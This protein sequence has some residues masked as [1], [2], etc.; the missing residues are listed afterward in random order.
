MTYHST[1]TSAAAL[2]IAVQQSRMAAGLTQRELADR[3][4]ISQRYVWELESG[5]ESLVLSRLFAVLRETGAEMIVEVP[6]GTDD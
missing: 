1:I 4:S 3:L 2:G 5:K 6:E